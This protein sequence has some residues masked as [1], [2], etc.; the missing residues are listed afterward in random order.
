MIA[1]NRAIAV[2]QNEGPEPG[3]EEIRSARDRDRLPA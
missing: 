2:R 1:L 3:L